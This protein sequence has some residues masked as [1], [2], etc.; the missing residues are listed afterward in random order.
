MG[1]S[2]GDTYQASY[3]QECHITLYWTDKFGEGSKQFANVHELAAYLRSQPELAESV[4]YVSKK[5]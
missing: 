2:T 4:G 5:K 3:I 1:Q